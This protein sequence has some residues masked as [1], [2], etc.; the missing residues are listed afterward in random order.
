MSEITLQYW[1]GRGLMEVP[2]V[3]LALAGKFPSEG[4]YTDSR[5]T[6]A[7]EG[8]EANLGRMP[9][10]KVGDESIGQSAAINYFIAVE[11]G[12]LGSSNLEAAK[13][14]GI[15]EH[16]RE[17]GENF[18]KLVA[19]GAA[20][21]EEA[22]EK[23]FNGGATDVTGTADGSARDSRFLTWFAGRI[24]HCLGNNGFAVGNKLSLADVLLH[25]MFA[26]TLADEQAPAGLASHRKEPFGDKVKTSAFLEKHPK[27]KASVDAVANHPNFQRWLSERGS[28]GF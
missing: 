4:A 26:E 25:N 22:L 3:M 13:I 6:A 17:T 27:I 24:E 8:S 15:A 18:R 11:N 2:R 14:T 9:L 7:P 16:L 23:W 28:Q 5:L 1:G 12:F 20:P 21:T 19:Y 10:C